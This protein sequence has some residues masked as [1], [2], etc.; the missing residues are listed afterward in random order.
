[1]RLSI[2]R[3]FNAQGTAQVPR[4]RRRRR[5]ALPHSMQLLPLAAG[6]EDLPSR[7]QLLAEKRMLKQ[8]LRELKKQAKVTP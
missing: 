6:A 1:M 4:V 7:L 3:W 8:Q 2:V 5:Q